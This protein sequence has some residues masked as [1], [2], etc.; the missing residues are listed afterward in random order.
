MHLFKNILIHWQISSLQQKIKTLHHKGQDIKIYR[1]RIA[2]L[3]RK[4]G[5]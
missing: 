1:A 2:E 4:K 5:K 3:N